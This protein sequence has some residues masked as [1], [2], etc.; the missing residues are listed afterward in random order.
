MTQM[1]PEQQRSGTP[2]RWGPFSELQQASERMRRILEQ[3][4]GSLDWPSQLTDTAGW[5]PFVDIEETDD[6]Y[7]LEADLP[8]AK[9]EDVNIELA[10]H[11]L[12]IS[13]EVKERQRTG[14]VRRRTRRVGRFE[15]RVRLPDQADGDRIEA[16]LVNGVLTV[17]VPKAQAAQ[18]RKIAV[19][20]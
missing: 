9:R 1:L 13:G 20:G 7:V 17:R 14:V 4:F 5:S 3:T 6:A 18:R 19:T 10:G 2:E 16:S 12:A 8:G 15:Y 11:E